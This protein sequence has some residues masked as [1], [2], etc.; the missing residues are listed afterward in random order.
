MSLETKQTLEGTIN[1]KITL[2]GDISLGNGGGMTEEQAEQL[3]KN[4]EDIGK[5]SEEIADLKATEVT[6]ISA[7][8]TGALR[9]YFTNMQT[10]LSQLAYTTD[11]HIGSTLVQNMRDV[12]SALENRP[13][14]PENGIVQT[15]SV[16]A[17]TS[18]VT[19]T[20]TGSVLAIA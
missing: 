3:A 12:V 11:N 6:G 20:Q 5:L 7:E 14:Q 19:A 18:G 1:G 13:E 15:G 4:T 16:L 8:L 2:E 9:V 17:I 10:L